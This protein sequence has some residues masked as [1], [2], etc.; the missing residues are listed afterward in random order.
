MS[1]APVSGAPVSALSKI[2]TG[3]S[4]TYG[5]DASLDAITSTITGARTRLSSEVFYIDSKSITRAFEA[6]GS[7]L[8]SFMLMDDEFGKKSG[9]EAFRAAGAKTVSYGAFPKKNH[10]K[11]VVADFD[12]AV[13]T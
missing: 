12:N 2:P 11:A 3:F 13:I 10:A 1:N 6:A 9:L 8:D 4:V 7:R 5:G